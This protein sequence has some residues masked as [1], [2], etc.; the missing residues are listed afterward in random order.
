MPKDNI[1]ELQKQMARGRKR[2]DIRQENENFFRDIDEII[3]LEKKNQDLPPSRPNRD[4]INGPGA[5]KV[6]P[7][8]GQTNRDAR[9][10]DLSENVVKQTMAKRNAMRNASGRSA[11]INQNKPVNAKVS[12]AQAAQAM[13]PKSYSKLL[14]V[15]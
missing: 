8:T 13:S 7:F 6:K 15:K 5:N 3:R 9:I 14:K 12:A 4:F 10:D 2:A 1:A 11:N